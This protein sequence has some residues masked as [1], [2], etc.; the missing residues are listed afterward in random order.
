MLEP[1]DGR[2]D[3]DEAKAYVNVKQSLMYS[4]HDCVT[5]SV[6]VLLLY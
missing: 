3:D 5:I 1:D 2:T 4:T 6:R